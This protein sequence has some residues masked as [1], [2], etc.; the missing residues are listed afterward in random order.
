MRRKW[1]EW[2]VMGGIQ[3]EMQMLVAVEV[4]Q[5]LINTTVMS[6]ADSW[7]HKVMS[8]NNDSY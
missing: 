3:L 2:V 6:I 4:E 8:D 5:R 7:L 1:W